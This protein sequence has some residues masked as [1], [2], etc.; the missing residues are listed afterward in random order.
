M[1]ELPQSDARD[2]ETREIVQALLRGWL[3]IAGLSLALGA[4]A[5]TV[6]L[7]LPEKYEATSTVALTEPD[8]LFQFDSRIRTEVSVP[9]TEGLTDLATSLDVMHEVLTSVPG[10]GSDAGLESPEELEGLA[11]ATLTG[12]LLRLTVTHTD[13]QKAATLANT[14]AEVL[15]AR[16]HSV[17]ASP[18]GQADAFRR[19][20]DEAYSDWVTAQD[21]L[22]TYQGQNEAEV[23]RLSLSAF[24]ATLESL[25][26][27]QHDLNLLLRDIVFSER[28]LSDRPRMEMTNDRDDLVATLLTLRAL[29]S[30][31]TLGSILEDGRQEREPDL[32]LVINQVTEEETVGDQRDYLLRLMTRVESQLDQLE[33]DSKLIERQILTE[34]ARHE[35]FEQELQRLQMEESLAGETYVALKRKE[36]EAA[37]LAEEGGEIATVA[38]NGQAATLP[39]SPSLTVNVVLGGLIG[40]LIGVISVTLRATLL[41][42]YD[43]LPSAER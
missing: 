26:R 15:V 13:P 16:I 43:E 5:L 31:R 21:T 36:R 17:Y 35:A 22:V 37:L 42:W 34:Q 20:A 39:V 19:Q 30:S 9:P 14:W 8:V 24:E 10:S 4:V 7:L 3:L 32:E 6:S 40:F 23:S 33:T 41:S 28:E 25:D 2:V 1:G 18:L 29:R 27:S 38:A 12:N 11:D